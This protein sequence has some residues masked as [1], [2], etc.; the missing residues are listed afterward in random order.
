MKQLTTNKSTKIVRDNSQNSAQRTLNA[1]DF[2]LFSE[3]SHITI[4]FIL[5]S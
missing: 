3:Q 2:N 4:C 5:N 1:K